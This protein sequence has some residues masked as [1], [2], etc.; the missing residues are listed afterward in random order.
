VSAEGGR[1]FDLDPAWLQEVDASLCVSS[2]FVV[3]G[4]TGDRVIS[5]QDGGEPSLQAGVAEAL[6]VRLAR[7]GFAF[8]ARYEIGAGISIYPGGENEAAAAARAAAAA[9][10]GDLASG[11]AL[12]LERLSEAIERIA[13]TRDYRCAL[14]VERAGRLVQKPDSPTPTE[15]EF[16]LRAARAARN[17]IAHAAPERG[18]IPVFNPVIWI[19]E[20]ERELPDWFLGTGERL[21]TAVVPW[22]ELDERRRMATWLAPVFDDHD[23]LDEAEVETLVQRF[24]SHSQGMTLIDM[25]SVMQLAKDRHMGLREIEDAVRGYRIGVLDNPWRQS[26]LREKVRDELAAL[27]LPV[28]ER[29]PGSITRRVIGQDDAVRRSLDILARSV[30]SLTAAHRATHSIGPRGVLFFAGPTGV[31]KTELAKALTELVFGDSSAYT[32]FDMSEFADASSAARLIGAPPGYIGF[33]AGGELTNAVRERPF[34]LILFDEIEKANQLIFDKFLQILEDGR[35]TDGRG[36]TTVFT[37][38][39]L[40]FTSNLGITSV[41]A[42]GSR[43][44]EV[45]SGMDKG[46]AEQRVLKAIRGFFRP[47]LVNRLGGNIIVFDYVTEEFADRILQRLLDN[48]ATRIER[49]YEAKLTIAPAAR[50]TIAEFALADLSNGG[51]GI[52]SAV[53]EALVNPLARQLVFNPP[54]AGGEVLVEGLGRDGRSF[55]LECG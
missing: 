28:G 40:V 10:L 24:A 50:K 48:V 33:D 55:A 53:E 22:P 36:G 54:Q 4:N 43:V 19:V 1:V 11:E 25:Q 46:E 18:A 47:E 45:E 2:Q 3:G 16:F 23:S 52:G 27:E 12:S 15:Y 29:P 9:V 42:D 30:T 32:R 26:S 31:G 38:A 37:E 51:R 49:E 14:A 39:I 13:G 34:S 7:S 41:G 35:L 8:L 5:K 44:I 6:W 20:N 21:R 17:A